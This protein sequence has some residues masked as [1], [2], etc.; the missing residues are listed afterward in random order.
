MLL[1][2]IVEPVP[3]ILPTRW[4]YL[5]FDIWRNLLRLL[6]FFYGWHG[7]S[8][9]G[10]GCSLSRHFLLIF[11]DRRV[12][13]YDLPQIN[14]N[15]FISLWWRWSLFLCRHVSHSR[16]LRLLNIGHKRAFSIEIELTHLVFVHLLLL[17]L[18]VEVIKPVVLDVSYWWRAVSLWYIGFLVDLALFLLIELLLDFSSVHFSWLF[19][20][21]WLKI[22]AFFQ[23]LLV[24]LLPFSIQSLLA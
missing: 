12:F 24:K 1:D 20:D 13:R 18:V 15:M 8:H 21:D 7:S 11:C 9:Q 14:L 23:S 17:G 16:A 5:F 19:V 6:K 10:F 2:L 4:C 3:H 22:L